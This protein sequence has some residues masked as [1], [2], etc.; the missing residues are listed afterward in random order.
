MK[1]IN[2]QK[3][4]KQAQK[5][6]TAMNDVQEE[7]A[8]VDVEGTA[9]GGIVTVKY[10]GKGEFVSIKLTADAINPENPEN[11]SEEDVEA[12]EDLISSAIKD[13]TT[14]ANNMAQEKMNAVTGGMNLNLPPGIF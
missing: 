4:L 5:M 6:Q 2:I 12:L 11:V 8:T 3:M 14:R 9:G 1:G 7:L 10:N 13:A